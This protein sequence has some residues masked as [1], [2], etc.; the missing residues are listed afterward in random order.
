[1]PAAPSWEPQP[2]WGWWRGRPCPLAPGGM[3]TTQP[4]GVQHQGQPPAASPGPQVQGTSGPGWWA[5]RSG[6]QTLSGGGWAVLGSVLTRRF[7]SQGDQDDRS[8]RQCRTSS[9]SSAGSV[10]LGRY[11]P[12]SR[13]PQHYSRPGTWPHGS[14]D[15]PGSRVSCCFSCYESV[16]YVHRA[17]VGCR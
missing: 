13:S 9:P 10:S 4:A 1:M 2:Q 7:S 14:F 11:T 3:G 15:P 12:T 8:S 17:G 5:L 16:S 6:K